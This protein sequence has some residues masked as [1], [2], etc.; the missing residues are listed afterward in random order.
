MAGGAPRE[1]ED[2]VLLR[3]L[4]FPCEHHHPSA[5]CPAVVSLTE[6]KM[7]RKEHGGGPR[8]EMVT[9]LESAP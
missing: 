7:P 5:A 4:T 6:K 9:A 3:V 1:S 2:L 8:T